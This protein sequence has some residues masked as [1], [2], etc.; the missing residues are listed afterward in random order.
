MNTTEIASAD[1]CQMPQADLATNV[2]LVGLNPVFDSGF[3]T[4]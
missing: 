3:G 2:A 4:V 1:A